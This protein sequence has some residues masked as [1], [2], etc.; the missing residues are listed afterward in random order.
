MIRSTYN[1][2]PNRKVSQ[3]C[4]TVASG[5]TRRMEYYTRGLPGQS[6]S[7]VMERSAHRACGH[8]FQ[9]DQAGVTG[10]I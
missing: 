10:E 2:L 5:S 3:T 4:E 6:P 1:R 8:S 9:M 7:L